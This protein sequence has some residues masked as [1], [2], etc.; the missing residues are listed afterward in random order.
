MIEEHKHNGVDAPKINAQTLKGFFEVVND[1][2]TK[3]PVNFLDQIKIYYND[4]DYLLYV[5]DNQNSVWRAF[6]YYEAP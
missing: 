3:K 6:N 4:P 2:P 1:V 5:Y